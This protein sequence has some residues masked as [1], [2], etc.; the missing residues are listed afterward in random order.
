ML[1]YALVIEKSIDLGN[2]MSSNIMKCAK[3]SSAS[4]Y[5]PSLITAL[6]AA[7]GVQNKLNEESLAPISA[8]TDNKV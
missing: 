4:L 5:Y 3:H 6:C 1:L 7:G 2:F 8:I